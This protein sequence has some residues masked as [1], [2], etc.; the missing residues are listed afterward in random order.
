MLENTPRPEALTLTKRLSQEEID[1]NPWF[2]HSRQ[3]LE[4]SICLPRDDQ[5]IFT[6]ITFPP[7]PP[8]VDV[9]K[10]EEEVRM[11]IVFES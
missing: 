11:L 7:P 10:A 3:Y 8:T 2:L 1:T 6:Q 4:Y 9:P 5:R